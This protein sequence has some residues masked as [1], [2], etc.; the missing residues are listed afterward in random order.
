MAGLA[1]TLQISAAGMRAQGERLRVVAENMA[2]SDSTA[3]TP[4]GTPY[5]RKIVLFQNVLD[6][7]MGVNMVKVTKHAYDN[8][9]FQ[10]KFD[11]NHPAAD[12]D[13]Y[14]QY[15]NVNSIVEMMD[16]RE[17]RRGYEANL[18]MVEV[19]KSMLTQ[20]IALLK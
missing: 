20:T 3:S 6:R 5:R 13:G 12:A 9:P 15:P 11:P 2:N 8:S 18:N 7:Q 4:G 10:K 16:M 19:S 1:D 14:V 17:A